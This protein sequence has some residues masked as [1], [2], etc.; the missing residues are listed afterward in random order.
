M[1]L[2]AEPVHF[3]DVHIQVN[4]AFIAMFRQIY[5]KDEMEVL[6]E[7]NHIVALKSNVES[8]FD[9]IKFKAFRKYSNSRFFYWP[10]KI[11]GEWYQIFK[12]LAIARKKKP[13][14]LVWLCLFPTGQLLLQFLSTFLFRRQQQ[15]IVLHG[16]MEY[17]ATC[18]KKLVD[19]ALGG[20]LRKALNASPR[21]VRFIVLGDSIKK[22]VDQLGLKCADRIWA[23]QHP[24]IYNQQ[25]KRYI[26]RKTTLR[27]CTFGVLKKTKNAHL[28]FQLAERFQTEIEAGKISFHTVGKIYPDMEAYLNKF[29]ECY[30][31]DQFLP[32]QEYEQVIA[33][34]SISIFCYDENMYQMSASGTLHESLRLGLLVYS[35]NNDYYKSFI[36]KHKVG[37]VFMSLDEMYLELSQMLKHE[38]EICE[39]D[40]IN[41]LAMFFE[42]NSVLLQSEI[43]RNLLR[44]PLL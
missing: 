8:H 2:I 13:E 41:N 10:Q 12:V 24:Y 37:K 26:Q 25:V 1:I 30:K 18:D 22:K 3:G 27:I 4:S 23:I 43:L 20:I 42:K 21:H 14:L 36:D 40:Y 31:P 33:Q 39:R 11:I 44:L 29:V 19:R 38:Q 16:E 5:S 9:N 6:A 35:L 34:N 28:F 17:L 15:I 7:K 32:Q